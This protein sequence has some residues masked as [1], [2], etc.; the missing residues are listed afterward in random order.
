MSEIHIIVMA[1]LR[2]LPKKSPSRTTVG[3]PERSD[4]YASLVGNRPSLPFRII[5]N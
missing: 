2:A 4:W 1:A 5:I 3:Y